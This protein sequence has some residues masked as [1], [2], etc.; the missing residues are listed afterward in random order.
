MG[1]CDALNG[2]LVIFI[3]GCRMNEPVLVLNLNFEPLNVCN[4]RRAV[5]LLMVGK[6][7]LVENGRGHIRTANSTYP[8]PS[9]I[10]LKYLIRRPHPH[11]KLSKHEIFRRD[12]H[13]CQYCGEEHARLTIDHVV[14]RRAGGPHSWENLVAACPACNRRKGHRTLS[15]THMQLRRQPFEPTASAWYL[16]GRH[17]QRYGEWTRYLEGW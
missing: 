11:V 10:R 7:E 13:R 8:R 3:S 5:G 6:A 14:P 12:N 2:A 16:Y 9:V 17:T 1:E 15:E 4:T